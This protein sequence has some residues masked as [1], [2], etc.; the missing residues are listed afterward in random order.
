MESPSSSS[1]SSS[2][3]GKSNPFRFKMLYN[4]V[5]RKSFPQRERPSSDCMSSK[6]DENSLV[7]EIVNAIASQLTL[8]SFVD[9]C[10]SMTTEDC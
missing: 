3:S 10:C 6:V 7:A 5:R 9:E 8:L 1:S 2:S 4:S